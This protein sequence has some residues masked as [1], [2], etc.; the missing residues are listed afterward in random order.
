MPFS[1][2]LHPL[3]EKARPDSPGVRN[4][5][6]EMQSWGLA[7]GSQS[8]RPCWDPPG[9]AGE[10]GPSGSRA[11]GRGPSRARHQATRRGPAVWASPAVLPGPVAAAHRLCRPWGLG[12]VTRRIPPPASSAP[13]SPCPLRP[14]RGR[15]QYPPP[16]TFNHS[17][18]FPY[19][20]LSMRSRSAPSSQRTPNAKARKQL[21][22]QS[23][24]QL[25][26]LW[27]LNT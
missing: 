6:Q 25:P 4:R 11:T 1:H 16:Q 24:E 23:P 5:I 18:P 22:F 17:R 15:S 12:E 9:A 7:V 2:L 3:P 19:R 20:S 8:S 26:P 10:N 13:Q 21:F 14:S 27:S